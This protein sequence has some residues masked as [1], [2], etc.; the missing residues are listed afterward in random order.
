MLDETLKKMFVHHL[1]NDMH[2][3]RVSNSGAFFC[4]YLIHNLSSPL[5]LN[6]LR[7][8]RTNYKRVA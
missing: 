5:V 2:L 8:E 1:L 7:K 6:Y 4:S 3:A